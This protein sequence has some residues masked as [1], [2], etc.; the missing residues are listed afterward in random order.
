MRCL[1]KGEG[2]VILFKYAAEIIELR[3]V[4]H[5]HNNVTLGVVVSAKTL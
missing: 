3:L 5:A 1:D 2:V 4:Y